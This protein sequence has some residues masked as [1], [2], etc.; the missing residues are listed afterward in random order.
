M[1]KCY[2]FLT[3]CSPLL[4]SFESYGD[5]SRQYT[6]PNMLPDG[7][8]VPVYCGSGVRVVEVWAPSL[9]ELWYV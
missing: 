3:R 4:R 1:C 9:P 5:I 2:A 6:F 8:L 7:T